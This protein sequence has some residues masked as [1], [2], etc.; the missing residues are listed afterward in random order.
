MRKMLVVTYLSVA[1]CSVA[2]SAPAG[3]ATMDTIALVEDETTGVTTA[4][5]TGF[6]GT[7]TT[8]P[9][10]GVEVDANIPGVPVLSDP[11]QAIFSSVGLYDSLSPLVQSDFATL[12]ITPFGGSSLLKFTF[13]SGGPPI[14]ELGT[15]QVLE[16]AGPDTLFSNFQTFGAS[17]GAVFD[18]T[19]TAVSPPD[20]PIPASLPLLLSGLGC[21]GGLLWRR[22]TR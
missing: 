22:H 15:G 12:Q 13:E 4:T 16:T 20:I 21:L 17:G 10:E 9:F 19:V 1:A 11:T 6:S 8:T 3:A 7:V 5:L 2:A 14:I 18:L